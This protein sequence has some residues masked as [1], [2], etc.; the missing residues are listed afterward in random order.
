MQKSKEKDDITLLAWLCWLVYT[1][2]YLGKVNY[3]AN[4][5]QIERLYGI[6][7]AEAGMANTLFFFAY[8]VGQIVNGILCK[9]YNIKY[10]IFGALLVTGVCNF[11][12]AFAKTFTLIKILWLINGAALSVLWPTLVRLLSENAP[13]ERMTNISVLM[14]T[15]VAT[16]TLSIYGL[17]AFFAVIDS[18]KLSFLLPAFII[19]VSGVLWLCFLDKLTRDTQAPVSET[20]QEKKRGKLTAELFISIA[21]LAV[22]AVATNLIKDGLTAWLPSILNEQ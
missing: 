5:T 22:A 9:K 11:L 2:S 14:G 1:F 13:K 18:F 17:S 3:S 21:F 12:V 20:V 6:T 16:G 8:G 4:I 7:H 10:T 19:P 15:T